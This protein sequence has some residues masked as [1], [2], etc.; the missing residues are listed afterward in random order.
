MRRIIF[1]QKGGVGKSSIACNLAAISAQRGF[2][3]LLV[4][5]DVQGN[6][7]YYLGYDR[8]ESTSLDNRAAMEGTIAEL[9]KQTVGW[10]S[11]PK[12]PI[13]FV[14]E[15][16]H[17]NLFFIP[18]SATL[19]AIEKELESRYKMFKLREALLV[20]EEDFDHIYVDTP[21]NLNFYSKSALIAGE[22]VLV[23]FDCDSFSR[24]ALYNLLNNIT[25]LQQD[26]NPSLYVEGIIVN[27]FNK[28]A[29]LPGELIAE[30]IAEDL[31]VLEHYL[32]SSVKM[33]ESHRARKPLPFFAPRHKLT[34]QFMRLFD[35]INEPFATDKVADAYVTDIANSASQETSIAT[36]SQTIEQTTVEPLKDSESGEILAAIENIEILEDLDLLNDLSSAS[37]EIISLEELEEE[38]DLEMEEDPSY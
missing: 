4:D 9:L 21:P 28:Q 20:L 26:H 18:S 5:M 31:P 33:K 3:T 2:K 13:D 1:N 23:P 22:R 6:S 15:T 16:E 27:Q 36:P 35:S 11:A 12:K 19:D 24:L 32:S 17:K 34:L 30:L 38:T 37:P 14:R 7:S 10:F 25:E 8:V 29:K